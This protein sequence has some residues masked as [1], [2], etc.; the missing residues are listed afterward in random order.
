[1]KTATIRKKFLDFFGRND[2]KI[3]K[4]APLIPQDDPTIL[5]ISAGMAP[6]KPYFLG[7]KKDLS[8]AASCQKCFRTTDIE[9]VGYTARHHTFFEMLGNFSFGDYFKKEAIAMAWEFI[10]KEVNLPTKQLYVSVHHSDDEALEIWHRDIGIPRDRIVKLGDKDNFWTIGV[11]PSG[12]CSEIYIDQGPEIGCKSPDCAPG[13][14]CARFLEFWNLVFTQYDRAEDGSLTPLE[15]KNIDTGMGLER[16]ASILQGKFDNFENDV[17]VGIVNKVENLTGHTFNES[18]KIRTALKVVSDHARALSFALADGALPG[19]EGRG[20]V[21][22]KI[23]RRASRF[24][25]SYLGQDKPFL[26]QI[27][28]TVA[29]IMHDYPEVAENAQHIIRI[30]KNEEERFLQTLKTGSDM[31]NDYISELKHNKKDVLAGDRAFLLH[32]TYGFPLDLTREIC[33]EEKLKVD[34]A[35]FNT[36]LEKQRERGRANVVSAFVNFQAVNPG[37]YK[38]TSFVGYETMHDTGKVLDVVEAKDKVLVITDKTPFY[39]E[40]GGQIGDKGI[41]SSDSAVFSVETTEKA[42][43]VFLHI[44]SWKTAAKFAKD[45]VVDMQVDK[46]TRRATMRNHTATHLLHKALQEILGDHVKQ[47]GSMVTPE[48]LRFDFTHFESIGH[49]VLEKI[50]NR[51]NEQILEAYKV[52][53]TETS[54]DEAVKTGAMALFGE[55]YGDRVRII[56][57]GNYSKE[58]CGG[59]HIGNSAE[60][61]LFSIASES[62][63]AAGVRRIEAVTGAS[64][65]NVLHD[66]RKVERD[67]AKVLECDQKSLMPKIEKIVAES[68]EL[69]RELDKMRKS[70]A[71]GR[72]ENVRAAARQIG[73]MSVILSR[74]EGLSVDEMKDISDQLVGNAGEKTVVLLATG[75]E[76]AGFVL[77]L[78]GDLVKKGLHAGKLIKDI[79]KVAG[80]SGGGRPDMATAGGKDVEKI[81][82]ALSEAEKLITQAL[83]G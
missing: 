58:L 69:R 12:P 32:D 66:M 40:S 45:A 42:E 16:L 28:P 59:T 67:I 22:R 83:A 11:G 5:F 62:S 61:G 68:R 51:V 41:I 17:F 18:P 47:A 43:N 80:G 30:V 33:Q 74:T 53:T 34:E 25:Y 73:G 14:D 7:L 39:A 35:A 56:S 23:L 78:T 82:A 46:T 24:G 29:E 65:L 21:L 75:G 60:I 38:P 63:I 31:L 15:R 10:T 4:S 76:K 3:E 70:D 9:N 2:H 6:F 26:H 55:K 19:N 71:L 37:D 79:A 72:I 52:N 81:D 77:K 36:E 50:E 48:R 57:V 44:G 1:M 8:R 64:S 54:F 27:V 20:Y 49:D 13:C